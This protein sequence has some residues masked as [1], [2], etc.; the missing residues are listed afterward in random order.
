MGRMEW[1]E[2]TISRIKKIYFLFVIGCLLIVAL[3]P[4]LF[5][6]WIGD[7]ADVPIMMSLAVAVMMLLDMWIR[8]YD[9]FINGVGKIRIQMIITVAMAIVYIP[10]AYYFT[11]VL[12]MGSIGVV[13]AS[14]VSYSVSAIISPIQAKMILKGTAKGIWDK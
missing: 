9:Y 14:I 4:W 6:I 11:I 8:I 7:K 1:I 13:L 2:K 12:K 5:K 3:S 10:L